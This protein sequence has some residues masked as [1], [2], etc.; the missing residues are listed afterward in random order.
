MTLSNNI[1]QN[2]EEQI[3]FQ[4]TVTPLRSAKELQ[5]WGFPQKSI[6]GYYN[7][8]NKIIVK[9][10]DD[11]N[12][13]ICSAYIIDEILEFIPVEIEVDENTY[14]SRI[15]GYDKIRVSELKNLSA[16][17]IFQKTGLLQAPYI[18]T[19]KCKGRMVAFSINNDGKYNNLICAGENL[20]EAGALMLL[21][22]SKENKIRL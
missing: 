2:Q 8:D 7:S 10:N 12:D 6:F 11:A 9:K 1:N 21:E 5:K 3:A 17:V 13:F 4:K 15:D 18:S 22:L 19:C 16:E 14:I 20:A